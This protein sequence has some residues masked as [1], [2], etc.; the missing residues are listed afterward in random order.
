ML[1][2]I[3][4]LCLPPLRS[5]RLSADMFDRF[6]GSS[7]SVLRKRRP[8]TV[9]RQVSFRKH[10]PHGSGAMNVLVLQI[11]DGIVKVANLIPQERV[12]RCTFEE[13]VDTPFQQKTENERAGVMLT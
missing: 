10:F 9:V 12:L 4:N 6:L 13:T 7:S 8:Q 5:Q 3:R 2:L 11:V 1:V